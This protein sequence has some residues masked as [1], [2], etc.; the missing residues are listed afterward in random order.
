MTETDPPPGLREYELEL[1][2][3]VLQGQIA[4]LERERNR[5]DNL[6]MVMRF[7]LIRALRGLG[8]PGRLNALSDSHLLVLFD[9]VTRNDARFSRCPNATRLKCRP[10]AQQ[11]SRDGH[12]V[13]CA[14]CGWSLLEMSEADAAFH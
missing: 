11:L 5:T 10:A 13:G 4:E 7:L 3:A 14:D 2:I 6:L 1:K 12:L 8:T 9:K